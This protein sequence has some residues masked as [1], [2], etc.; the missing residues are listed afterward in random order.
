MSF[1]NLD[2]SL[3]ENPQQ[4]VDTVLA[5]EQENRADINTAYTEAFLNFEE[6]M[7]ASHQ[8]QVMSNMLWMFVIF[9]VLAAVIGTVMYFVWKCRDDRVVGAVQDLEHLTAL[10][11]EKAQLA[12]RAMDDRLKYAIKMER[13]ILLL[14]LKKGKS[15]EQ[16]EETVV[17][18]NEEFDLIKWDSELREQAREIVL[19]SLKEQFPELTLEDLN[20]LKVEHQSSVCERMQPPQ[21]M[22]V[23]S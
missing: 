11:K 12:K 7:R 22:G 21:Q 6:Q 14:K 13:E 23:Q 4:L 15:L 16:A 9:L 2:H 18:N 3:V 8:S 5:A 19:A 10:E 20:D 17:S 1:I